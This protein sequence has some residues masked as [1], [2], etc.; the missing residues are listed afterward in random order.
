M[1]RLIHAVPVVMVILI[2]VALFLPKTGFAQNLII[3]GSFEYGDFSSNN[4]SWVNVT[5]DDSYITGW[6]VVGILNWHN[7][8]ETNPAQD[9]SKMIDLRHV[10]DSETG[11]IS[12]TF[13]TEPGKSYLLTFWLAG[14]YVA[15]SGSSNPRAVI[16][17]ISGIGDFFFAAPSSHYQDINWYKQEHSFWAVEESTTLTFSDPN[18]WGWW[19]AFID[20]VSVVLDTDGDGVGDDDDS[21]PNNPNISEPV[22]FCPVF[23]DDI[24]FIADNRS[25]SSFELLVLLQPVDN[26][27][28]TT[29]D[30]RI[31]DGEW[32]PMESE[33]WGGFIG[34]TAW[35]IEDLGGLPTDYNGSEFTFRVTDENGTSTQTSTP[36]GLWKVPRPNGYSVENIGLSPKISWEYNINDYPVDRF[37]VRIT[38][39]DGESLTWQAPIDISGSVFEF[40][41]SDYGFVFDPDELYIIRIEARDF[42]DGY[43]DPD[44]FTNPV[45]SRSRLHRYYGWPDTDEDGLPD[46]SDNCPDIKNPDQADAD[47]DGIGDV[48][49]PADSNN[50]LPDYKEIAF[51]NLESLSDDCGKNDHEIEKALK[52][53]GKSL[54]PD[55]WT[56]ATH[57]EAKHGHKVFEEEKKAVKSLMKVVKKGGACVEDAEA[58]IGLMIDVDYMLADTALAEAEELCDDNNKKC[59]KEI[60]KVIKEM[61]KSASE[62]GKD[63]ADHA[64]DHYKHAWE[65]AL[66]AMKKAAEKK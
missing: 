38:P 29:A 54:N 25:S 40:D 62:I 11:M 27:G 61:G 60:A 36:Y 49:D 17:N 51:L 19:G 2:A 53:L 24:D 28:V 1:R 34:F 48:C 64:I 13:D 52:H 57:P 55:L 31:N 20:D 59:Q 21:C 22:A 58:A 63:K 9:G 8:V 5:T 33:D 23:I 14:P 6:D 39:P 3:N 7:D 35:V 45:W 4:G 50:N 47:G 66:K 30:Y 65:H 44:N 56:D 46:V 18:G 37:L 41:F 10:M 32:I 16:A 15:G 12:Q 26:T 42:V 43:K